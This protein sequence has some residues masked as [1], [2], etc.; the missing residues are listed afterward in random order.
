M[1]H[2]LLLS[3]SLTQLLLYSVFKF[4]VMKKLKL[5]LFILLSTI[6]FNCFTQTEVA[7]GDSTVLDKAKSE[8]FYN[9]GIEKF[10]NKDLQGAISDFDA[11]LILIPDFDKALFNRGSIKYQLNDY[12]GAI[13]DFNEVI[14]LK[15]DSNNDYFLRGRAYQALDKKGVIAPVNSAISGAA[16]GAAAATGGAIG[17]AFDPVTFGLGTVIGAGIGGLAGE[18]SYLMGKAGL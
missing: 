11:A 17:T 3:T 16:A 15:P 2:I 18:A 1:A 5:T 6:S 9:A 8:A 14:R 10:N 12:D 7:V 4:I 13:K